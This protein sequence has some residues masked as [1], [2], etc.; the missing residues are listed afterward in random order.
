MIDAYNDAMP[1]E[2]SAAERDVFVPSRAAAIRDF[3]S[4]AP[5]KPDLPARYFSFCAES[6]A[7]DPRYGL[8]WLLRRETYAKVREGAVKLKEGVQ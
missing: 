2:W 5:D 6:L 7:A 1:G 8:D 4:V 3:L